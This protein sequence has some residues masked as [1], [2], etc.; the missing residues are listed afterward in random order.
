MDNG[1]IS[2]DLTSDLFTDPLSVTD[3]AKPTPA[4]A[5]G[6]LTSSYSSIWRDLF[7]STMLHVSNFLSLDFAFP[8]LFRK[9]EGVALKFSK[10]DATCTTL[11][12]LP[13]LG[14]HDTAQHGTVQERASREVCQG[15]ADV[16]VRFITPFKSCTYCRNADEAP[17]MGFLA[18]EPN[19]DVIR[20]M[21]QA[22]WGG[23]GNQRSEDAEGLPS[24]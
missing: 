3:E 24:R 17:M 22:G 18:R 16:K 12:K 11:M 8:P 20:A 15:C 5:R 9:M 14:R 19:Y 23:R 2:T 10:L 4:R 1:V 21:L 13:T 7:L 6:V